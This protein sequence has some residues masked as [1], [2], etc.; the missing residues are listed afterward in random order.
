MKEETGK[1]VYKGIAMPKSSIRLYSHIN[2]TEINKQK[3]IVILNTR[4][5]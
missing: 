3:K 2:I 1:Y 5:V 4:V